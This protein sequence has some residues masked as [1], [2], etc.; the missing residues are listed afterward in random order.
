VDFYEK[1]TGSKI[2]VNTRDFA[3]LQAPSAVLAIANVKTLD[4]YDGENI[5]DVIHNR[6]VQVPKLYLREIMS[7][8]LAV[9]FST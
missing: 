4:A 7:G 1:I 9:K 5:A 3:K 2:T 8:S 6:I